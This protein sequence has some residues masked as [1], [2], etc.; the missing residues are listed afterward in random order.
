[1]DSADSIE[2]EAMTRALLMTTDDH[3]EFLAAFREGG[4]QNWTGR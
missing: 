4:D 1:M 2:T 3:A